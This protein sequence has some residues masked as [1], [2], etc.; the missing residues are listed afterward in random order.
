[1]LHTRFSFTT[2]VLL[3][4][5]VLSGLVQPALAQNDVPELPL[6]QESIASEQPAPSAHLFLRELAKRQQEWRDSKGRFTMLANLFPAVLEQEGVV[7]N[8]EA[9]G[10]W[11]LQNG[12]LVFQVL[13]D[14]RRD[15]DVLA[16]EQDRVWSVNSSEEIG[17]RARL[18]MDEIARE[19]LGMVS[20]SEDNAYG[21]ARTYL[22]LAELTRYNALPAEE[23]RPVYTSLGYQVARPAPGV[24][25]LHRAGTESSA[26]RNTWYGAVAFGGSC[27]WVQQSGGRMRIMPYMN[28]GSEGVDGI[29]R[30]TLNS[31]V[32]S[33]NRYKGAY[34]HF[35]EL[36]D[37][38]GL[39]FERLDLEARQPR[40]ASGVSLE[41]R[42][43]EDKLSYTLLAELSGVRLMTDHYG[44][45][46]AFTPFEGGENFLPL[47]GGQLAENGFVPDEDETAA[48]AEGLD[49][50][51]TKARLE[52]LSTVL[53]HAH[54]A[55]EAYLIR[56][57]SYG[58]LRQLH[59]DGLLVLDEVESDRSGSKD[60]V[61]LRMEL[62]DD[63]ETYKLSAQ[64]GDI[65]RVM[66]HS[67]EIRDPA[68]PAVEEPES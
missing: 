67:G 5:L 61:H 22:S 23:F 9:N 38:S 25:L 34:Q 57:G 12:L 62:A 54:S 45:I 46:S 16:W 7:Y 66:D 47:P 33:Q 1:M 52:L 30:N 44:E 6:P 56:H 8:M 10:E 14:Y 24:L 2:A 40:T 21:Q 60:S 64:A 29:L 36:K 41:F 20:E 17:S 11:L 35:A 19:I 50:A 48:P 32:A 39:Y 26:Q 18:E 55:E 31:F 3:M 58:N 42:L 4:L 59:D 28:S 13:D 63:A 51:L 53:K 15:Y 43:A 37:L 27:A 68:A 49:S 65:L